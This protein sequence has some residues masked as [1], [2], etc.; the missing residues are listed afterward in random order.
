MDR[1]RALSRK[2]SNFIEPLS[3]NHG[4][5][6]WSEAHWMPKWIAAWIN[7]L[8][9]TGLVVNV[10]ASRSRL[11]EIRC[12]RT[13]LVLLQENTADPYLLEGT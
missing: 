3:I 12:S 13:F 1:G 2:S 9:G 10:Y 7:L 8:C 4:I 5:V 11:E 6:P